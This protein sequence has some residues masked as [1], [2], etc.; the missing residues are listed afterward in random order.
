MPG[1]QCEARS[2]S[3]PPGWA[4][5]ASIFRSCLIPGVEGRVL[6]PFRQV[7]AVDEAPAPPLARLVRLEDRMPRLHEVAG[8][9][10]VQRIVAAADVSTVQAE[11][12]VHPLPPDRHALL[13]ATRSRRDRA[14][15]TSVGA[16]S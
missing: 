1:R 5:Q 13:A 9:V 7:D 3:S 14:Q 12:E 15:P 11:A 8:G 2:T 16:D 6:V 10:P 4:R